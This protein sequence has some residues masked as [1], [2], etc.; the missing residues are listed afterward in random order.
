[1]SLS[2]NIFGSASQ[3]VFW[4]AFTISGMP[5]GLGADCPVCG[6]RVRYGLAVDSTFEHCGKREKVPTDWS[7]LPARSLRRGMPDLPKG[8]LMVDTWENNDWERDS[9]AAS[10]NPERMEVPWGI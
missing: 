7:T 9:D 1:M 5:A 4:R 10:F 8:Y 3:T 6:G 2:L